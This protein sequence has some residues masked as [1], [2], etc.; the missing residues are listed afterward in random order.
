MNALQTK[1]LHIYINYRVLI[2]H[3]PLFH[4]G[5]ARIL[6]H[7]VCTQIASFFIHT[8]SIMDEDFSVKK[9]VTD[10]HIR[11]RICQSKRSIDFYII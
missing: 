4:K 1:H 6:R 5:M 7:S 8:L 3:A 11:Y 9:K 2:P 10:N